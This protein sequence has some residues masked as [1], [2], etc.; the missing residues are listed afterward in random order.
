MVSHLA[1]TTS[2]CEL[3][4]RDF[5]DGNDSFHCS[6]WKKHISVHVCV[7]V[8]GFTYFPPPLQNI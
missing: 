2:L 6:G 4:T 3:F 1:V 8:N 7:S 5:L